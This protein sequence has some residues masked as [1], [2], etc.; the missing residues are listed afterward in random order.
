MTGLPLRER[1]EGK[2]IGRATGWWCTCPDPDLVVG[3]LA[4]ARI[5]AIHSVVFCGFSARSLADRITTPAPR[6]C[7]AA[8]ACSAA[9]RRCP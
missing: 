5:G 4:C 9:P 6:R 8:M 1:A 2:G 7:S 3:V